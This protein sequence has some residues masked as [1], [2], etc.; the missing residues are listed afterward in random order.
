VVPETEGWSDADKLRV[1]METP[2][3]NAT[4]LSAFCRERGVFPEQ[5]DRLRQ[6]A[7]DANE[8]PVFTFKEQMELEK[9]RA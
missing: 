6:V 2:G 8:H 9:L 1:V 3:L 4:E 7:Q 5:V